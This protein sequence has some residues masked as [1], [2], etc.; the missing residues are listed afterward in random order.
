MGAAGLTSRQGIDTSTRAMVS[1]AVGRGD[2]ALANRVVFQGLTV[3]VTFLLIIS[4]G[5]LFLTEP[6]LRLLHVSDAV[7]AQAVP[8]MRIQFIGQGVLGLQM[9][10]G[11]SLAASGDT[12][13]PMRATMVSRVLQM[14]LSPFLVFGLLGLP[15]LG[16]AGISL[17]GSTANLAGM[18]MNW[19]AL[20]LGHSALH[21][22]LSDYRLDGRMMLQMVKVGGPAA[23]TGA[24]R[25]IAQLLL[26]GI[27]SPFGDGARRRTRSHV[28][29]RC[30]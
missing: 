30:L 19:R 20:F 23:Y 4:I 9:Y 18:A 15:H 17:A 7:M 12:I 25:S 2:Q 13:T 10:G 26:V 29:S 27:V 3:N 1:R 5:G 6:M 16:I 28:D 8:Y 11:N 22:R 24:E 21:L 14:I